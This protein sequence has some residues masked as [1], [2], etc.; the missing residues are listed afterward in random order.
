MTEKKYSPEICG[1]T[2]STDSMLNRHSP[3]DTGEKPY[4]YEESGS[5]FASKAS[6]V[7]HL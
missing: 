4:A 6:L 5:S 2:F 1:S 3:T 7:K